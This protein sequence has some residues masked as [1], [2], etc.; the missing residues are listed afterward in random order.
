MS[1][2]KSDRLRIAKVAPLVV[3]LAT[4]TPSLSP[5]SASAQDVFAAM[6]DEM[7]RRDLI[8]SGIRDPRVLEA[9]R[10]VPRHEF[11]PYSQRRLAYYDMALPI[12]FGQTI[13]A[14]LIVA[15]MTEQL[16]PQP[17]DKVLEIGTGSGYQ[18]AVLSGLVREVYTIEIVEPLAA[19]AAQTLRRLGYKNVF[20]KAGDGFLGWP[21]HAPFD[22]IIVTCSPEDIPQ[23]L[24]DQL[25]EGGRMVIPLGERYRQTLYLLR[26]TDGRM[27]RE[28][29]RPTLFVPMTGE[30]EARRKIQPD[31]RNPTL[32]NGDFEEAANERREPDG[33]YYFRQFELRSDNSAPSGRNYA[34]FHNAV[35]GR[36]AR[37]LQGFPLDGRFVRRINLSFWVR[38]EA[39]RPG[40]TPQDSATVTITFYDDDRATVGEWSVGPLLGTFPWQ[41]RTAVVEVPPAGR[42]AILGIGMLGA[43]G[44]VSFD[45]IEITPITR[46]GR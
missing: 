14:T 11:V 27:V 45:A 10:T 36:P 12:G 17:E 21:E 3:L 29:L 33:W 20:V 43:V 26:K 32:I 9:M 7:V 24:V 38:G 37:A 41:K 18:A 15:Y 19:Q 22:K 2:T 4:F 23:P 25:K 31:P 40:T 28:A 6:R 34:H 35:P 8:D 13:S 46:A 5:R 42:E 44:T 30:A 1:P 39:I 16:D